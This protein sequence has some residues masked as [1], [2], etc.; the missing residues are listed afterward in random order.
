M[1]EGNI[2]KSIILY[3]I[4]LILGNLMQQLYNTFDSLIVGNFVGSSALAA[5][6]ASGQIS[7]FLVAFYLGASSGAGILISQYYGA[8]RDEQ[9]HAVIHNMLGI[10]LVLGVTITILGIIFSPVFLGWIGTPDDMLA[11]AVVYLRIFFGG[12]IFQVLYNMLAAVLNAVGNS[13]RS[14]FYLVISSVTNIILDLIL[15]CVCRFGI[16]GAAWATIIS[17][18]VCCIL[19]FRY[20]MKVDGNYRVVLKDITLQSFYVKRIVQM[21]FP[22]AVQNAVIAFSSLLIQSGVNSYG[23]KAAAG[24]TAYMKVDGFDILPILSFSLAATTFVGQNI[25][26]GNKNRAKKGAGIIIL[27]NVVYTVVMS[28]V[29]IGFDEQIISLFSRDPDVIR[30]GVM[31]IWALAP[32]YVLLGLIHSFAGAIRGTGNTVGPMVI[33]LFSLCVYRVIWMAFARPFFSDIRGVYLTYPTSFAIGAVLMIGYTLY[34]N[35][36]VW[37]KGTTDDRNI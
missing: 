32:F 31:C 2:L 5:V 30:S 3:S 17:Q 29:M 15:V 28:F 25:G 27:I 37:K 33:I 8:K 7:F 36:K 14:L 26:A 35:F 12:M 23:T 18:A 19:I 1:T 13:K 21:G 20:L 22:A 6:G 16:A 9:L 24:F 34:L 10:G 4:P 11:D